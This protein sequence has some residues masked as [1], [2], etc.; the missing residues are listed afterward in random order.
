MTRAVDP[1]YL[2]IVH[3]AYNADVITL[4]HDLRTMKRDDMAFPAGLQAL[5]W[6]LPDAQYV[7]FFQSLAWG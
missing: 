4:Q 2:K 7:K 6:K 1:A 3:Q 5:S